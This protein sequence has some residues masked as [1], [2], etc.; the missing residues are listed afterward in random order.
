MSE[1]PDPQA[2]GDVVIAGQAPPADV[3]NYPPG[4]VWMQILQ[5]AADASGKTYKVNIY[6]TNMADAVRVFYAGPG[7]DG[8]DPLGEFRPIAWEYPPSGGAPG[9]VLTPDQVVAKSFFY[10]IE[11]HVASVK[12]HLDVQLGAPGV[13]QMG[14]DIDWVEAQK[15]TPMGR[16]EEERRKARDMMRPTGILGSP[17]SNRQ[18]MPGRVPRI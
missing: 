18:R 9:L 5:R 13:E 4:T 17:K 14:R 16:I 2:A 12:I 8:G 7:Y 6:S 11:A 1:Q 10:R 15:H 3:S